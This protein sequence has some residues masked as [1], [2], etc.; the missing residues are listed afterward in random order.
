MLSFEGII[1]FVT[2]AETQGFSSAARHLNVNVS[3]VSR[4]VSTLEQHLGSALFVR[5]TR[6]VRL[7]EAGERYYQQC[8]ELVAGLESANDNV[9]EERVNLKGTL[10]VSASGEFAELYIAPLLMEFTQQ[11]PQL[12]IDMN[13]NSSM[14]DF[15]Q[16]Q[17]D[18]SIRYGRLS[19]SNLVAR[20]LTDRSLVA[21]ASPEYLAQFGVPLTP[22]A[23]SK[24]SCLITNNGTWL[25]QDKGQP[26]EVRVKGRWRSNSGRSIVGAARKGLGIAYLPRSS[27]DNALQDG[28]LTPILAPFWTTNIATWIVFANRKFLPARSRL[29]IEFLLDRFKDWREQG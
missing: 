3:Q 19:D 24:H 18:F 23:L 25:F 12:S 7:T 15:T 27:Y 26:L 8:K 2:V 16:D 4:K 22:A 1:E 5:S 9:L 21:A 11:H 28:S 6:K 14:V 29:A 10:K 20:K 17:I 13:F